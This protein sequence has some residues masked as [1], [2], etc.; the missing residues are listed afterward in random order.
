MSDLSKKGLSV[1][2]PC[3]NEE[4]NIESLVNKAVSIL[5]KLKINY[6]IIIVNDG[7]KDKTAEVI[8][9]LEK[10]N[11]HI[12]SIYHKQ[13]LGYGEALKSGFYD[14]IYDTIVYTD[15]DGQFDFSQVTKFL[16]KIKSNDVVIGYRIKRRDPFFRIL[17]AKG[18]ALA[19]F[20]F[21]R[22]NLKDIDC[23]FK[24]VKKSVL[25]KIDHLQSQRGAMINA[26]LA[27]KAKKAGFRI[28]QVGVDHYPRLAGRPTGANIKVIFKSFVDL[29]KLWWKIK[30]DKPF[31][32]CLIGIIILASFLRLYRVSEYMTFL[33][34]EGRD[35]LIMKKILSTWSFPLIGPPMSVGNIYL[36]PLY[37]Y[38][39]FFSMLPFNLNP[40]AAA[41]MNG[42]IGVFS[43]V[44]VYLLGRLLFDKKSGL[45]AAFFYAISPVTVIYSRTSWNPNPAPFFSM[46]SMLSL[47]MIHRTGNFNWLLVTGLS[48]AA[49]VQMHYLSLILIPISIFILLYEKYYRKKNNLF[50][51]N[52]L[53]G[54]FKGIVAFFLIMSPLIIFDFRHNFLNYRA[55]IEIF[56]QGG[57]V[58]TSIFTNLLKIPD[59]FIFKLIGRYIAGENIFLTAIVSIGI[60][61]IFFIKKN[62][63]TIFIG[64]WLFVGIFGLSFYRDSVFDHYLNFLNAVPFLLLGALS[65]VKFMNKKIQ[66]AYFYA[67]IIL[68]LSLT[69]INLSKSPLLKEP[70]RQLQRT[71]NISKYIISKLEGK[72]Y[73]FALLSKNNY[74]SAY[75]FYLDKY[76]FKPK[77]VPADTT[78]QLFVVCEDPVCENPVYN[79]KYEVAAFGLSK[80][81][82]EEEVYG[83]K[84]Y[85]LEHN[86]TGEPPK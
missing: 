82:W 78:E 62:W 53:K 64:I 39:M 17:F 7:S 30:K 25:E 47:Y 61:S 36:G 60:L 46:V 27:I 49:A 33:G 6:E 4:G 18:W 57:S 38:M 34:D 76:G 29:L 19:L 22:L 48:I 75:V 11:D 86:P 52:V 56:T 68:F 79:S 37:Y 43:V 65:M 21:F 74:D 54:I 16:E 12:R 40:E 81:V 26:E 70:N 58:Q 10:E 69:F 5:E 41:I 73:N 42:F 85:K 20:I 45:I 80:V 72:D 15:G 28:G 23:G 32:F 67:L 83:V 51:S 63:N 8:K 31:F 13:N 71:Q 84:L 24:M 59:I 66:N 1:F 14:A 50:I 44:L 35:A 3:V 55:A 9:K 2:F 77:Q